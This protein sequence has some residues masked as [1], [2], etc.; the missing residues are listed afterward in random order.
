[1]AT[2]SAGKKK[3]TKLDF[4]APKGFVRVH[5]LIAVNEHGST[6]VRECSKGDYL[7]E[8]T[9]DVLYDFRYDND[10][11]GEVHH[12]TLL[13]PIPAKPKAKKVAAKAKKV[14]TFPESAPNDES[15]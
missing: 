8:G 3:K 9:V 6:S 2:R 12:A 5:V 7:E 11:V 10:L 14:A 13:L 4:T 15:E 1:M